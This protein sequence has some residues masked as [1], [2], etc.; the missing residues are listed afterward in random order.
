MTTA[1][2]ANSDC[3]DVEL[4]RKAEQFNQMLQ[5]VEVLHR[6]FLDVISSELGRGDKALSV[7]QALILCHASDKPMSLGQLQALSQYEGTNLA[8]NVTKLAD[9][10]YVKLSR[11]QWDKRSSLIEL[12]EEGRQVAQVILCALDIHADSLNGTGI[13]SQELLLLT[14][15]LKDINHLWSN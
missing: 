1:Y 15:A 5:S 14:R 2:A 13:S 12:T 7:V 3:D 6:R 8:Y 10:G 11:P 4:A 9:G